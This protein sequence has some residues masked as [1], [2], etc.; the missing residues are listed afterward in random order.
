MGTEKRLRGSWGVEELGARW[1]GSI[2]ETRARAVG[3][4][5]LAKLRLAARGRH[6]AEKSL[7]RTR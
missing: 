4:G 3:D 1:R 7:Q 2:R 6:G 5:R